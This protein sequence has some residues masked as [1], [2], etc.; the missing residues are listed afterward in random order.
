MSARAFAGSASLAL[1]C[2]VVFSDIA[3]APEPKL[4]PVGDSAAVAWLS[5]EAVR[6]RSTDPADRD[7]SDLRPLARAIGDSR[8][9]MLG[10]ANH[11]DGGAFLAKTRL[12]E[13]LHEEMGF[14]VVAFESGIYSCWKGWQGLRDGTPPDES[15]SRCAFGLWARSGQVAPLVDYLAAQA[16]GEDPL[17]LAGFDIQLSG[18]APRETLVDDLQDVLEPVDPELVQRHAWSTARTVL[19]RL[20][21]RVYVQ[22]VEPLPGTATQETVDG[23]LAQATEALR[24]AGGDVPDKDLWIQIIESLRAYARM[25]WLVD[26][27]DL[28][29]RTDDAEIREA[30]MAKILRWMVDRRHANRKIIVWA[31]TAHTAR[32]LV[33]LRAGRPDV[34]A[35]YDSVPTLGERMWS[36]FGDDL[37]SIALTAY[38]GSSGFPGGQAWDIGA[39]AVGS[40]EDLMRRAGLETAFLNLRA[41]APGGGWLSEPHMTRVLGYGELEAVW[42]SLLDGLVFIRTMTPSTERSDSSG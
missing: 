34:Q 27:D 13:F 23:V 8:V 30:G 36:A 20:A 26:P 25:V 33:S 32:N 21:T 19:Q 40:I 3:G 14:D 4:T 28:F 38:D 7:F 12:I 15:F 29:P 35:L 41:P 10:E 5:R 37:Y 1:I 18:T 17:E 2:A 42:P 9:V 11:G 31:A 6:I 16:R 22:G 24:R 39:A